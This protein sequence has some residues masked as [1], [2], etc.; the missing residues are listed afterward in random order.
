VYF[1]GTRPGSVQGVYPCYVAVDDPMSGR[2][3][4]TPGETT[5]RNGLALCTIH[6]RAFDQDLIGISPRYRVHVASRLL[7]EDDGP[8]LDLLKGAHGVG[9]ELPGS[10]RSRPDRDLLGQRFER[11]SAA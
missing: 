2:V 7:A 6:H 3:V 9:I 8:M 5:A 10:T 4:I 11:F 1:V